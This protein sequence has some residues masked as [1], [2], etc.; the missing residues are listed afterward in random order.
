MKV[1]RHRSLRSTT[2][3]L[4][5][6]AFGLTGCFPTW[7]D[8]E[9]IASVAWADDDSAIAFVVL[10]YESKQSTNPLSG[11]TL[12]RNMRHQLY[13]ENPNGSNRRAIG[14]E[15]AGQNATEL[16]YMKARG[17]FLSG[18]VSPDARW[19]NRISATGAVTEV[20]RV[21]NSSCEGRHFDVVPSPDGQHLAMIKTAP[22]CTSTS[23]TASPTGS[24]T[25]T[26]DQLVV[27]FLDAS[28]LAE[29][30]SQTVTL[31]AWGVEWTWRP[32]GDFVVAASGTAWSLAVGRAP[33]STTVPGCF[34]PKTTSSAWSSTGTYI[35][36]DDLAV[37]VA[38][39]NPAGAFGCQ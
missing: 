31:P 27:T 11:T 35:G 25:Q 20:A 6:L 18:A 2:A 22:G 1:P 16:Y 19:F 17:Y 39:Q 13:V 3:L 26:S 33:Q 36:S 12:K 32:A 9:M 4:A 38:G 37:V 28:T 7:Q 14:G 10:R 23:G 24:H 29:V 8:Q 30:Q 15:L 34:W 21:S 5:A